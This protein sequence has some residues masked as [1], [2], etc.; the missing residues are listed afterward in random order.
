MGAQ[1]FKTHSIDRSARVGRTPLSAFSTHE[2]D[3]WGAYIAE[4]HTPHITFARLF[5]TSHR[6]FLL[7]ASIT[8]GGAL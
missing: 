8:F 3:G 1:T 4:H 2:C 7:F 5:R 6:P